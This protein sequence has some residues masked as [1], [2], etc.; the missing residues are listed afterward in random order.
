MLRSTA[1]ILALASCG[2]SGRTPGD[3]TDVVDAAMATPDMGP[4]VC[5]DSVTQVEVALT[6]QIEESCAIW[7]SLSKLS[8]TATV[9]KTG[10]TITIDFG[11]GVVFSGP[12]TN[13]S[14]MLVY[15][16]DHPF[17]DGCGW[18]ATETMRG[19]M[20]PVACTFALDYDYVES[21]VQNNGGC[22][23]PC[24]ANADVTLDLN[25]VIL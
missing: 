17:T 20:D 19:T 2:P 4:H 23:S 5:Y 12:L 25:P 6:V 11:E 1:I 15:T 7:N 13:N 9:S 22:A 14:V 8:G 18:R 21:V 10:T 3:D 24:A 16:H